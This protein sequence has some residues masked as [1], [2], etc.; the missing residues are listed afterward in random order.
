VDRDLSGSSSPLSHGQR[1]LWFLHHLAPE[2]GAYN[3]AAVARVLSPVDAERLERA[4]QALV[5]RHGA[6]RTTFPATAGEPF[7]RVAG[8]LDF[9]LSREDATGWSAERLRD[10]LAGEAWRPF[11]LENGPLLRVTLFT[12]TPG[13]PVLLVVIHHIISDFWSLAIVM[14]ELPA[15]YRGDDLAPPGLSYDEHVRREREA[16]SDGR[17]E[18]VLAWWRERLAG[19]PTLELPTDRP[20]PAVQTYRGDTHRRRLPGEL[21]TAL[22]ARSR[23]QHGTLF[24]T[25]AAA[26]Q[27][28]LGRHADQDDL[29]I[30]TARSGRTLA[31]AAGTV[32]YF[33]NQ[34]VLRADLAGDPAFAEL[35]ERTRE[36]VQAAFAHGDYPLPLLAEHLQPERA[37]SRTPL[38]QVSFV[39]Q[40][41]TRGAEGL[42]AFALGEEGVVV[43]PEDFRLES[44]APPQPPSPFDLVLHCVDRQGGLSLAL[45]YNTDLFD[46]ATTAALLERFERLLAGVAADPMQRLSEL[47]LLSAA[48]RKQ[49][50]VEWSGA[51]VP[52]P[53]EATIQELFAEQAALRPEAVAVESAEESLTYGELKRRAGALARWLRGAGVGPEVRVGVCL[54]R[55]VERVV[56]TLAVLEAGGAYV[57]LDPAYPEE[58]LRFLLA[59]AG[60]QVVL[61]RK[62]V[63]DIKDFKDQDSLASLK[64]L[65]SL[66][67]GTLAYVMYTSGSTGKPK[68]VAAT[69][70]GVVRLVR[71]TGYVRFGPDEVFLQLAPYAFDASTFEIWG[72]LLHGGRLVM[73]PPGALSP[74]ELGALVERHGV[75]TLWLTTGLF[76]QIVE[77]GLPGLTG[78]RQVMTGGDVISVPHVR[79]AL[80]ALPA[81]RL[82]VFYGPTE[83]TTFTTFFPVAS[84]E[85]VEP[86][87]PLGVPIANSQVYVLDR[88]LTPVPAGVAG[89]LFTGGDGLARG[90]LDRPELTAE[91]FVPD[92]FGREPG[93]RLYRTGDRVRWRPTGTLEF[94]GRID[95]Q[96]KV[97][98]F[99][100]EPGEIETVLRSHPWVREAVVLAER[101]SSGNQRLVAYVAGAMED[102]PG[103]V[104]LRGFL[105]QRMPEFMLP[106]AFAFLPS[107]PLTAHAKFDRK[108]L[109]K[110][111]PERAEGETGRAPRTPA[112]ELLAEIF[113]EVLQRPRV[114]ADESFFDLGGHSLLATQV[115]SRVRTVFGVEL[116]LRALFEAPTVEGL[117]GWL[118]RSARDAGPAI[119]PIVQRSR[120]EPPALS[121]AQQRLWFLDQLEPGTPVYNI[122]A[123]VELSGRLDRTALAAALGEVVRRHEAL[124]TVFRAVEGE[125]VQVVG[126]MAGLSVPL[127]DLQSL[128]ERER[129]AEAGHLAAAEARRP[130][131]LSRGPLLRTALLQTADERHVLLLTMHHIVSDGWSLGVLVRELGA[132]YTAFHEGRPSPLPELAIQYADFAA[133]Q[134]RHLAGERLEAEIAWW[135][136]RLAG[137]PPTLELPADFPRPAVRG[138]RGAVLGFT[139]GREVLD[140]LAALSRRQGATLFMTLTAGFLALLQRFTGEEDLGIGTP[141]AGRTRIETEPLIGLFVNTLVLRGDLSGEPSLAELLARVRETT[142]AAYAHQEVPFERLVEELVPQ[143]DPSRPP[144][145]QVLFALQNAPAA[146]LEL[147]GLALTASGVDTGTARLELSCTLTETERGLEGL[148]ESSREL[149]DRS[150][151][152]RLADAFARLLAAAVAAPEERVRELPV[153][154]PAERS[155]LLVEW[156]DTAAA[157]RRAPLAH[158]LVLDHARQRTDALAV[159]APGERLTYG[160]L[161]A[162]ARSLASLLGR[163]GVRPEARVAL[164]AG[165]TVHR[166]VGSLAVLLAGGAYVALD[167][168]ASPERLAFQIADSGAVAVLA[169]R[170]L[171][172]RFEGCAAPVL[173]LE[174]AGEEEGFVPAPS[175]HP[176]NL[177]YVVYT[178]GS[179]GQPKGV[180]IPH[181]GL[182]NLV[183]WKLETFGLSPSDR[184]TLIANPAFDASVSELWPCLAAGG[185]LHIPDAETRLAPREI[186]RFWQSAGITWSF[187]P[188]PLA[189]EVAAEPSVTA[190]TSLRGLWCAGD[191]LH[192]APPAGLPFT[193]VNLYGPSEV[194]VASTAV[195]LPP[196]TPG[197]PPIGRPISNLRTRVVDAGGALAPRGVAG[198]LWMGG[199]GLGRG[200]LGRPALTAERFVPDPWS[201][202]AGERLYRTGDLVRHRPDG[203]LEFLGRIDHQ[204]KL[205][206]F[207][208]EPGEI[209]A[210]LREHPAVTEAVVAVVPPGR[211][212]AWVV[213]AAPAEALREHLRERL[214]AYMVPAAFVLLDALPLTP[215]GKLDRKALPEPAAEAGDESA[216]P[217]TPLEEQVAGIFAEVLGRERVGLRED[218]FALGGHSLLAT[219]VVS[220]VR[221][222]FGVELPVRVV[223]EAPTVESLAAWLERAAP[224]R[225]IS[226]IPA[227]EG[228]REEELSFAQQRLWFLDRLEPGSPLYNIA[229]AA[230][231]RGRLAPAAFAASLGEVVRRHAALRTTFREVDG[232]P[233]QVVDLAPPKDFPLPAVDLRSL[234]RASRRAEVARLEQADART[235]FD[236][237]HGPLLRAT[238]LRTEEEE[239]VLLL[240]MHHIVSDGWSTGVLVRELGALYPA[241]LEG[242]PSPLPELAMQAVD[243]AAWQR[244]ELAGA[245]LEAEVAWW[246]EHLA[247][248]P[249]ALDL[250]TDHPRP[251]VR[252]SR[253]AVRELVL[254]GRLS[255]GLNA[256][257][258][259]HGATLFMTLLAGLG[260]SL[261]RL[262]GAEDLAV[263]TPV[264][265]RTLDEIEPLIGFF[266]NTLALRVDLSG[267]PGFGELL[268]RVREATLAAY[269]HQELP[270]ER[271]VEELAPERDRGRPPLVQVMLALQNAPLGP[272]ALPGLELHAAPVYTGTA[273]FELTFAFTEGPGGLAGTIEYSRDLFEPTTIDRWAGQI[274]R[275]LAGAV[276]DPS[277]QVPDLPFLGEAEIQQALVEWNDTDSA[278]PRDAPLPELFAAVAAGLPDAPAILAGAEVWS[279][280]RLDEASS[281]LARHLQELDVAPQEPVGLALERSPELIVGMLAILK[282][283]GV[284]VPLDPGFPEERLRFLLA[285]AGARVVVESKDFKDGK[286]IKGEGEEPPLESLK[287]LSSLGGGG[288]ACLIYTSG[289]TGRPKGVAVPHRAVVRLVRETGYVRLGPGDR[290]GHA[291]N[292]SFDAAT[293][294]IWGALLNGAAVVVVPR[295]AVL[296]PEALAAVLREQRVTSLFLTTALF[297]RMSREAPDAFAGLRELLFGGEAADPAAARA[298]LAAGPPWRLLH[299]YGPTEST[300]FA[301]WQPVRDVPAGAAMLPIGAPIANTSLWVLDRAL[302]PVPLGAA[303]ELC[304]GGDGLA[305]G[306]WNRPELTAERFVPH[307]WQ[308]GGRLYRTGD[309]VRRLPDG[310][311][312]F[313]GRLDHQV[314]IRGFRIEPGE[315]EAVLLEHPR[316]REVVVLAQKEGSGSRHLV[317]YVVLD[318]TDPSDLSDLSD[319]KTVLRDF[320]RGRLPE[321]MLPAAWAFLPVL[322]LTP[323]GKVDRRGLAALGAVPAESD[324]VARTPAEVLLAGIFAEVLGVERV[325]LEADFFALGGHSLLATQVTSRIQAALGVEPPLRTLFDAPTVRAL[326]AW[327]DGQR[328]GPVED[329]ALPRVPRGLPLPLS[330]AQQRLW[331]L[332]QLEPGSPLYNIPAAVAMTGRLDPAAFAAAFGEVV[333]RHEA[334]RTTFRPAAGEPVQIIAEPGGFALP[335][336]DLQGLPARERDGETRRLG[337]AEARTPFDL[338]AG[339]L[340]RAT[341]VRSAAEAHT[342]LLTMHHIVSDGWSMGVLVRELGALYAAFL[343]GQPSPLPELPIQ[344]ADF[345]AWQ[346]RHLAGALL[347]AELAW[348]RGELSGMPPAL[349]LPADHPRPAE[350]SVR[351]AVHAF[352]IAREGLDGLVELSQR[353]GATLFMTL[354]A[355]FA[356]LLQRAT[357]EDDLVIGTPIAGRTWMETEPLIGFFVNA[358]ALRLDL[359]GTPV[360][361]E[362]LRRVRDTTLAA[363]AHQEVPFERLVEELAPERDRSRPP[364]FQV[365]L[366][367]QNAGAD[368]LALPGLDVEVSPLSTGTAK[369]ELSLVL[370][371][372]AEGLTGAIEH[373]RDLFD[374]PTI[375]RL[376]GHFARLLAA[377]VADPFQPVRELPLLAE[378][379]RHQLLA[380]WNDTRA[381]FPETTLLQQFFEAAVERAP[382]AVAAVCAGTELTYAELDARSNR[383]AHL[384]RNTG[385]ERGAPVGVWVERSLDMLVAVLGVLKA[386]GHYV[387]LDEAWPADRVESILAATGAPAIVAGAGLLGAVEEMR[388]RLPA[389]SNAVC[390]GIADPEPPAEA[391]D[392]ESVRAL[393]DF[394]AERAVDRVTAGGFVS[395]FTGEAMSEAEVDEYRDRVLSLAGPWLYQGARV[396]E[397][398]NGSGLLLW[399]MASRVDHVTGVDPSPRTQERNRKHAEQEGI[400]NVE[401]LTG[402]AHEVDG[403]L[404][405]EERFDL[406]LLASTVQF[407]PGP[408][409]L[410]R[411]V[412]QA[413]GRLAPGGALLVADV[414]DARRREELRQVTEEHRRE[415]GLEPAAR[416]QE[417]FLDED[418]FRDLGG[419]VHHRTVGFPNELRFRYDVLLTGEPGER[420]QRVWTGWHVDR[421]LA[422]RLPQ[423]AAPE[424]V[425]YVIHTSGST[426]EPKGIVVQHRPAAN[427][428]DWINRTFEVGPADRGLF[429]TSLCFDLSVYDVFGLLAAGGTVHVAT[430]EDLAD[431]DHLVRLLRTGGITLWDSAPAALV[432]LAPLFPAEPDAGSRLRRVLLSGDW[433]PVTLPDRVRQSFPRAQVM[434]LGGATEATVWSNWFPVGG[435]DPAWPSI[436]YGRPMANAR[437]H[438]LD[439]GFAPCPIGVP[440]DLYIGGDCLC[441]GYARR[442]ELTAQAFLPDP[443][444][445]LPGAR[446]YRTG[447]RARAF[448]DG[449]LEFLGRLDQQVKVRGYRIELGEIE[450]ALA[451]HPQVHEA[452][453]LAREDEPGDKRL[454]AYVVLDPTDRTDPTDPSD[455]KSE[456]A[457]WLRARLPEYM[458]PSAFVLLPELPVTPNGKL[459]RRAL[460]APEYSASA[461]YVAARTPT[462]ETLA[463]IWAA[464]LGVPQ[465]GREDGFFDLGG[466][467][468]L[469]TQMLSRVR[470]A[471][472]VELSLRLL[473]DMPR[474]ADLAAWIERSAGEAAG[475]APIPRVPREEPLDLSF[476]QQRLW[477]LDQL[478]PGS[479]A[480]NVPS[481]IELRGRLEAAALAAAL[482]EVVRRHEVLQAVFRDIGGMPV[483]DLTPDPLSHR[484]PFHRERGRLDL[485]LARAGVPPLP[486]AGG[487]M[488][489]GARG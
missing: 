315:I 368:R 73:P 426:G 444:S 480:Y 91:R 23:A 45:Q 423:V 287:P 269:A 297:T 477:F 386:G 474:L 13:G 253:G 145:V 362:L 38:F 239:H 65:P 95:T 299:V 382:E 60:V 358:L 16:L 260:A 419:A 383:L 331:F 473:F 451:R 353:Q 311:I 240:T 439:A 363:Y 340:L 119:V 121:F 284:Y 432:Q 212:V 337:T 354:L 447:D 74:A 248:V 467:S 138:T 434:A 250:P 244:R 289:S 356:G 463:A 412:R 165:G 101:E 127:I 367:F 181:K 449:N 153:L 62:D 19:L 418:L 283:G 186:V 262:T 169:E 49:L 415:R 471:F 431:P 326:A 425:A 251:A 475:E 93:G 183:E 224:S 48:E 249:P 155:A 403:L 126:E 205:R 57:P 225:E 332:D 288:L 482:G 430:R 381:P 22:R 402:F 166:V 476:A 264:A 63:K 235:P 226:R 341:L 292:V 53:R 456:L 18:P 438:V 352:A 445:V 349:E 144:L 157:L 218:F 355:G 201:G 149:F 261:L 10:R 214:P 37:A 213:G 17:G 461:G 468:L 278:Y 483:V 84:P 69:H 2:A 12:G 281:R 457:A 146:P 435:V 27:T 109:A 118:E 309:Q 136:G 307:P 227:R 314:K 110:I 61:D 429:V 322:P 329:A 369:F 196:G 279:Y 388:W 469:A 344:Y 86:T 237:R 230:G 255:A 324:T 87:V 416:R 194:S 128:P 151:A 98:G 107:L 9:A 373:S 147:P 170:R 46:A 220:R 32:G 232:R 267:A 387:A 377:A 392:P 384:L 274:L 342:V 189:E 312:D 280:R 130:F 68:G 380:E 202:G 161:A 395:A 233:V 277:R 115:T 21:A 293:W 211:L 120:D 47:P 413:L 154:S 446:L 364:L 282:A 206:G 83:N 210:V 20:R 182:R 366:A 465:V 401:L 50:L 123:A 221:S 333:R 198:E 478:E 191:R 296:S 305:V 58:R 351:G 455:L 156:N 171:A 259:Q 184:V 420:R 339:P 81:T 125:P 42:T 433:I 80:A 150:T 273:K 361:S 242:R 399:E 410:E 246:R 257:A 304:I 131:D 266:V 359:A 39:L 263:G 117:A 59:D 436:P 256:L 102:A 135:R 100:V 243:F 228:V 55:S 78:V 406:I 319:P 132:L 216:A 33:V 398:G 479:V 200:Y 389:L 313:L 360:F 365:V 113:A 300:T 291:A 286:D 89:E 204:I 173:A 394:V 421:C 76:H 103:P 5:D 320:L 484:P 448:A 489:E 199:I 163:L 372:T 321:F 328:T 30:G 139:I 162:R 15:L 188:T 275:L 66:G 393:W 75:T 104:E 177:A 168:E 464:L 44:M 298:V 137:M 318:R 276:A 7:R 327:I 223:F 323:S 143:R 487:A 35:L 178:S 241:F 116:P 70:R 14:R 36:S 370:T 306:Y 385:I 112:E 92:P 111:R 71:E 158:E 335:L 290:V 217:R 203:L 236:L 308:A 268:G 310:A 302:A 404:G 440:G 452:V 417:L 190:A 334:L 411:T 397:I 348:W 25:L 11:D 6:L 317:A 350:R 422:A 272:L 258:Q 172:A 134:R 301:S 195:P 148:L 265:G 180:A 470:E 96:V 405:T 391:I 140:R 303:G 4:F 347:E 460:P 346:R 54:D 330:F 295:E 105:R 325:D 371:E 207:R 219:R 375:A 28:L 254:G 343:G 51:A 1:S 209:E 407:F 160:E 414:L 193:F 459:D 152:Q 396:L 390:L 453:A 316:V 485:E 64:T 454:V 247:G 122:P 114:G 185:S 72:A 124:R 88:H 108:A 345:A 338:G 179:T 336:V 175:I 443:F 481:A 424:D 357:G 3:I 82:T 159:A 231:L 208:I 215:N 56:A 462:E 486:G 378:G 142:L 270:F 374:D 229:V 466:H 187:L 94:L 285:D 43:G 234:P 99:R 67:G 408:R 192:Q 164:C 245:R 31:Q 222:V 79:R 29:A 427:L 437:Y 450:V 77:E 197:A 376:A 34:V 238:L 379:E 458:I 106:A 488:G 428:V 141:I 442:P 174:E 441:A 133:W 129:A 90:Y 85:D 40:K 472:G 52:Y 400:A 271:L 252:S 294:E 97:R 24:M 41:E 167:P 26:F 8:R 409:Y 176:E